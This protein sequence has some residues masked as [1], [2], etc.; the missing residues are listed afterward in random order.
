MSDIDFERRVERALR[1]PV[2]TSARAKAAIMDSVRIAAREGAPGKALI[3]PAAIGG[4]RSS[5]SR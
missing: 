5:G 1:A 2:P 4:T 3:F